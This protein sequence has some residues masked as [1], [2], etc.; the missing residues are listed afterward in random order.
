MTDIA[1]LGFRVDSS[2]VESASRDLGQLATQ[3]RVTEQATVRSTTAIGRGFAGISRSL[4]RNSFA[5]TNAANQFSDLAVQ[6]GAGVSPARALSQQLPQLT[7]FMGPLAAVIGVASGVLIGL[8]GAFF[9]ARRGAEGA[10]DPFDRLS[11]ILTRLQ[12]TQDVLKLSAEELAETYGQAAGRVREFAVAQSE[13]VASQLERALSD[14]VEILSDATRDFRVAGGQGLFDVGQNI[15]G[16]AINIAEELG[17]ARDVARE[18]AGAFTDIERANTFGEQQAAL[19]TVVSLL[20]EAGVSASDLP[21]ELQD[22]LERTLQLSNEFDRA[23][24]AAE[25]TADAAAGIGPS[26]SGAASEAARLAQNLGLSVASAQALSS[27]RNPTTV[28]D[29]TGGIGGFETNDPRSGAGPIF[30]GETRTVTNFEFPGAPV[31][32]GSGGGAAQL[33]DAARAAESVIRQAQQAAIQ[34]SDVVAVLDQRLAS[35]AITQDTYNDA[36]RRAQEEYAG[37]GEAAKFF[38]E[39]NQTIKDGILDAIVAGGDLAETFEQVARSI[40][41]AAFEAAL[42]GSGPLAGGGGSNGILGNL[43]GGIF[44]GFRAS[45]GPVSAGRAYVVGERRPELF[46]PNQSGTILPQVPSGGGTTVNVINN[47]GQ[48]VQERRSQG[49]DG[50]EVVEVIVGEAV[51]RGK[52]DRQLGRRFGTAP[53]AL[54]RA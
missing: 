35:G 44:G 41:R 14:Q 3:A 27:L 22:A 7:A 48:P 32:S 19:E 9:E 1:R 17:V 54:A 53:R 8:A 30:T 37:A 18:L 25:D 50:R 47:S 10:A 12:S 46:V 4:G 51:E 42:F 39:Q 45:G 31:A 49:P 11:D 26:L 34:Y 33:S 36:I 29:R 2:E 40:A 38:E 24:Q 43:F 52:I 16:A 28:G 5:V 6:I 20:N 23:A 15:G 13:L 21:F